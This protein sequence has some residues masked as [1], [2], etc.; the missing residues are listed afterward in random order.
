MQSVGDDGVEVEEHVRTLNVLGRHLFP[1][2]VLFV[3]MH[4]LVLHVHV[5]P[6]GG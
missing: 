5:P 1:E 6:G 2:F 4:A 3:H